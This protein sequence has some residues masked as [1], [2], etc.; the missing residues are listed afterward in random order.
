MSEAL[1]SISTRINLPWVVLSDFNSVRS[2]SEKSKAMYEGD[3][4]FQQL[5]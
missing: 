5:H 2:D 4:R 3:G 1:M